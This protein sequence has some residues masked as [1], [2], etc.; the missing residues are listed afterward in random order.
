[1]AE[2]LA[3]LGLKPPTK[4]GETAKQKQEREETERDERMRQAEA[5][6]AKRDRERN[7]RLAS[8]QNSPPREVPTNPKKP[9]P[10]PS[11]K[12]RATSIGQKPEV[13]RSDNEEILRSKPEQQGKEQTIKVQQNIEEAEI[14]GL[15]YVII[16][17]MS[18]MQNVLT[19]SSRDKAER[20]EKDLAKERDAAQTRLKA[21]EEQVQARK[22]GKLEEKRKRQAAEKEAKEKQAKLAAQRA[23]LEAAKERE[24]QLQLELEGLAEPSS[25]DDDPMER[26]PQDTTPTS[27]Q[28]LSIG[29][30][31]TIPSFPVAPPVPPTLQRKTGSS[32]TRA[33]A[34]MA[35]QLSMYSSE[36]KNP[37][38][39]KLSQ[40]NES[41]SQPTPQPTPSITSPSPNE[42]STNPFHRLTQ[43]ENAARSSPLPSSIPAG[44]RPSRV[45]PEDDDWSVVESTEDSSDDAESDDKPTGGSA[46][47]LASML[48][49][50]MAPPRPLSAMDEKKSPTTPSVD[51]ASSPAAYSAGPIFAHGEPPDSFEP[52][53]E[54]PPL[55]LPMPGSL[56]PPPGAP[57][58]P[59]MPGSSS[60][61][62]APV[63]P[64]PPPQTGAASAVPSTVGALLGEIV[65]GK[66]LK[67]VE[68]KD[69]SQSSVAGR[70][71][72]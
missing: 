30:P 26:T 22:V 34:S 58:P 21:L 66:G 12:Q 69:R 2:R 35:P 72:N 41:S 52:P 14:K 44:S 29:T 24:R 19:L 70:V 27:S 32:P 5:E 68:T 39:K 40:S 1:M 71:L 51:H 28:I 13:Q 8:E 57:P 63:A 48:F 64:P 20:Q 61:G 65:K 62:A 49:G 9:P 50:T 45:R 38:F 15:E 59:P 31:S 10:P 16:L 33:T 60:G 43:Q 54:A 17:V 11:R 25:D 36:T 56:G 7:R 37:F 42:I 4:T 3:A 67:K 23:E 47:Q 6:D 55:P 46:K 18:Y 53:A